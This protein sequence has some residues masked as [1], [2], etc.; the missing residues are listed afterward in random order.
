MADSEQMPEEDGRGNV[1]AYFRDRFNTEL[2]PEETFKYHDWLDQESKK[3]GRDKSNDVIDYDM[4]GFFKDGQAFSDE[5][6]HGSD[7]YKKPNHPS[8]SNESKYHGTEDQNG[9]WEGGQWS[10]E[11]E[12]KTFTPSRTMLGKTHTA[13]G[14]QSYFR[15]REPDYT[16]ILPEGDK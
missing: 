14:M 15:D 2:T 13:D 6:G 9:K 7:L 5:N 12:E 11:G 16:L 1:D 8:F 4:Q 10:K 3:A